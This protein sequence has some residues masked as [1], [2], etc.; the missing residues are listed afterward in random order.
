MRA[1]ANRNYVGSN[2]APISTT[3]ISGIG[4]QGEC[5]GL[6]SRRGEFDP[7]I[8]LQVTVAAW[9]DML[10]SALGCGCSINGRRTSG[11]IPGALQ[12]PSRYQARPTVSY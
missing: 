4:I 9:K 10:Q 3:I 6:P 11:S 7:R 2:P 12:G 8:P 5:L 1:T